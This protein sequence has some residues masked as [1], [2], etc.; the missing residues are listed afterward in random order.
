MDCNTGKLHTLLSFN[1][2]NTTTTT[3]NNIHNIAS[4]P[5]I[6]IHIKFQASADGMCALTSTWRLYGQNARLPSS[7]CLAQLS[8]SVS[9]EF[10]PFFIENFIYMYILCTL[11][12]LY[13]IELCIYVSNHD[14]QKINVEER[15]TL[16]MKCYPEI[17]Q[18]YMKCTVYAN[19]CSKE[20]TEKCW[21][22]NEPKNKRVREK[23]G[24]EF[25]LRETM[26]YSETANENKLSSRNTQQ[27]QKQ[28]RKIQLVCEC[29]SVCVCILKLVIQNCGTIG[30][31]ALVGCNLP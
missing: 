8:Q 22:S 28:T 26:K 31:P 3:N 10:S 20:K 1:S 18:I 13:C 27:R 30:W 4:V 6:Y 12:I 7:K 29:L 25:Q 5:V 17:L 24:E 2:L 11:Y 9:S 21:N 15:R 23:V 14:K 16:R 19:I